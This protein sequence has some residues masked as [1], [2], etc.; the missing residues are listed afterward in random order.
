MAP[1]IKE[2]WR[3][4]TIAFLGAEYISRSAL[5]KHVREEIA[6]LQNWSRYAELGR[7]SESGGTNNARKRVACRVR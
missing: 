2:I 1:F 4:T 6:A 7:N 5:K 3:N